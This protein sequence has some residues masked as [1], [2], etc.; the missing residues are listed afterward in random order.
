MRLN[1]PGHGFERIK[2]AIFHCI[3][4]ERELFESF[5]FESPKDRP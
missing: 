5:G 4:P 1:R 2:T 3:I